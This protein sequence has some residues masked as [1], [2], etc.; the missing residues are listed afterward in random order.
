MI[1]KIVVWIP[2]ILLACFIFG[3]SAQNGE[4]SGGLS[5]KVA[6]VI[7]DVADAA[8]VIDVSESERESVIES[9]Q[10]P[11]RKLAHMSEYALLTILIYIALAVDGIKK[12][13]GWWIA[14]ISAVLFACTDEFH[15]LFVPGRAGLVTDVLIDSVGCVIGTLL[16]IITVS[17]KGRLTI[18][19][20]CNSVL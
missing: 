6:A 14:L 5:R 19:K 18:D 12:G 1:K 15:Q 8:G 16:C 9:I 7:V 10:Y 2:V 11:V 13:K 3:F 20:K 4:E 17:I